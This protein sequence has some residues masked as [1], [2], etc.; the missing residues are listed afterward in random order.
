M[1]TPATPFIQTSQQ[2]SIFKFNWKTRK[3][4]WNMLKYAIFHWIER[5]NPACNFFDKKNRFS[6]FRQSYFPKYL[7]MKAFNLWEFTYFNIRYFDQ[8]IKLSGWKN[9]NTRN[10]TYTLKS[11]YKCRLKVNHGKTTKRCEIC[12]KLKLK[13]PDWP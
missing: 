1:Q 9:A 13:T 7:K 6:Y 10:I 11:A 8:E 3:K 4:A 2:T 5:K 12:S